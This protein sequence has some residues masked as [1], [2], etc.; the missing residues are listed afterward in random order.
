MSNQITS[1]DKDY[2][3]PVHNVTH[4]DIR[5]LLHHFWNMMD[6]PHHSDMHE[7]EPKI[8]VKEN[9]NNVCVTAELPGLSEK[10]IDIEISSDGYLTISGEKR[11]ENEETHQGNY[12]SEI[13][14]GM[15]KRTIPLPWDLQFENANA[16]YTDGMLKIN[17]PKTAVEQQKK[18]KISV[19][20]TAKNTKKQ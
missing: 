15:V 20:K 16:E 11:Q 9:K 2:N 3:V 14:Y 17:I 13:S 18:K 12:F 4:G 19:T 8:E 5:T 1:T 10:D 7:L 6:F